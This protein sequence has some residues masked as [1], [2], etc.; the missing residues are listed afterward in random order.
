VVVVIGV[1]KNASGAK[2]PHETCFLL[3]EAASA[4]AV[5][6]AVARAKLTAERITSAAGA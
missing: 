6:E 2:G 1:Q 3:Y 4:D 5:H